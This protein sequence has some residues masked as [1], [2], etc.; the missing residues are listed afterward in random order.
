[1]AVMS[2]DLRPPR[3]MLSKA[4]ARISVSPT[5]PKEPAG[6]VA[7][8][9]AVADRSV[10]VTALVLV[11]PGQKEPPGRVG[12]AAE[13]NLDSGAAKVPQAI[14]GQAAARQ[15]TTSVTE[16]AKVEMGGLE[17]TEPTAEP[18]TT[19]TKARIN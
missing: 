12:R 4:A 8:P 16:M 2:V 9:V 19:A 11:V 13:A 10:E 15:G 17:Q 7:T 14:R 18:A 6:L 3:F 1:M 5:A